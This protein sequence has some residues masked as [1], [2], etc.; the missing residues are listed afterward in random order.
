M[1]EKL[2][3]EV[4][5]VNTNLLKSNVANLD[6]EAHSKRLNRTQLLDMILKERYEKNK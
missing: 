6:K 5:R 3:H 2:K 4:R 1:E